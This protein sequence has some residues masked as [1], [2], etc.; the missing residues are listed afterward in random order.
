MKTLIVY[1]SRSGYTKTVAESMAE[2]LGCDI[3]EIVDNKK[4]KGVVGTASAYM[5][6]KGKTTIQEIKHNP[7][8]YDLVIIGTPIWWYTCTPAITAFL[9]K[10]KQ[11]I[12]KAAFFYSCGAD[13][14][15]HVIPDMEENLGKAP[16][17]TF[18]VED[19]AINSGEFKKKLDNFVSEIR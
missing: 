15:H 6:P 2:K 3:E 17:V 4:R 19:R 13:R 12:K 1:Y 14:N 11:D 18:G 7:K 16:M 10:Y 5:M 9:T 8:D